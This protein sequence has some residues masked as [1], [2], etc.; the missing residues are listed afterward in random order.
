MSGDNFIMTPTVRFNETPAT[1][2]LFVDAHTLQVTVPDSLLPGRY[3]V[4]VAN[5]G[6]QEGTLSRWLLVG[7]EVF[8]PVVQK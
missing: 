7:R 5:P 3:D 6:G 2:V 8:L 4:W 1:N